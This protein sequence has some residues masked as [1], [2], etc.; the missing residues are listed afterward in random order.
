MEIKIF[1]IIFLKAIE[2]L[3]VGYKIYVPQSLTAGILSNLLMLG[4]RLV[5]IMLVLSSGITMAVSS[6]L[7]SPFQYL[8]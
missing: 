6:C 5:I 1:G 4:L 2:F 8:M 3:E 7:F